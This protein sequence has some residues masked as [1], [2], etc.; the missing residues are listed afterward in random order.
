MPESR[1]N[2][3]YEAGQSKFNLGTFSEFSQ[4]IV[5]DDKRITFF[6]EMSKSYNLGDYQTFT[7]D[8]LKESIMI[9]E[10]LAE[11]ESIGAFTNFSRSVYKG[12]VAQPAAS[13][14]EL[15]GDHK[16]ALKILAESAVESPTRPG[17]SR[18][19]GSVVGGIA[20][21]FAAMIPGPQQTVTVPTVLAHYGLM[22]AGEG[23]GAVKS[24]EEETGKDLSGAHEAIIA[25]GYGATV[26]AAERLGFGALNSTFR[27]IGTKAMKDMGIAYA[28][29][30]PGKVAKI[31]VTELGKLTN[32]S[33]MIEGGEE[34]LEQ[35]MTNAIDATYDPNARTVRQMLHGV[36]ES[37]LGGYVG[38]LVLAGSM[39]SVKA[40]DFKNVKKDFM[41]MA[42]E[43][44]TSFIIESDEFQNKMGEV[45]K[46]DEKY[47]N[48]L[49]DM[50]VT[51]R[52][53]KNSKSKEDG[54]YRKKLESKERKAK[55]E[56]FSYLQEV[57][58]GVLKSQKKI[59]DPE[60]S[61]TDP[62]GKQ[63]RLGN[64]AKFSM[65]MLQG[66][67]DNVDL[68][69]RFN[70]INA[71]RTGEN[72]KIMPSIQAHHEEYSLR[73]IRDIYK[74]FRKEGMS[75]KEANKAMNQLIFLYESKSKW[76]FFP[77]ESK[78]RY[79]KAYDILHNYLESSLQEYK[80]LEGLTYGFVERMKIETLENIEKIR[81]RKTKKD[82][83]L[84]DLKDLE[85]ILSR[86]DYIRYM[87][88]PSAIWFANI[89]KNKPKMAKKVLSLVGVK[90]RKTITIA[91][92]IADPENDIEL[93][94][95]KLGDILASYGRNK[96]RDFAVLE[97][98]RAAEED[99]LAF[100]KGEGVSKRKKII[101]KKGF[102]TKKF[103]HAPK[104]AM[105]MKNYK[106]HPIL[107]ESIEDILTRT[108][109]IGIISKGMNVAKMMAFWNPLFLP[110][111]DT[112]Q[113]FMI[114][115]WTTYKL[116]LYMIQA[117]K[118]YW[119]KSDM[120][121]R[122]KENGIASTPFNNPLQQ[123]IGVAQAMSKA[124]GAWTH[125]L[126]NL[127]VLDKG[128]AL[129]T[130]MT[131]LMSPINIMKTI[132][133]LSWKTARILDGTVRQISFRYLKDKGYTD[134][135]AAQTAALYHGDYAGVPVATRQK[136]NRIFFTPT[137]KIAMGK[138][139]I[140]MIK[141]FGQTI[142]PTI[143]TPKQTRHHMLAF[144]RMFGILIGW[145][146][147]M[148]ALG[149][150]RDE[151]GRRYAK[152]VQTSEG[153]REA[154]LV[155]SGPHNMF[156]KYYSRWKAAFGPEV[157]N[158][159]KHLLKSNSWEIHPVYRVASEIY[160]N[161]DASGK[162]IVPILYPSLK[163]G[164]IPKKELKIAEYILNNI[165][166]IT[167][168][169]KDDIEDPEAREL[170]NKELGQLFNMVIKPFSF[171][172]TRLPKELK[173]LY[174]NHGLKRFFTTDL[175]T[176]KDDAVE[177]GEFNEKALEDITNTLLLRIQEF[178]KMY[179]EQIFPTDNDE[180]PIY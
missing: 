108:R 36:P 151:F 155:W 123:T 87:P 141:S 169:M 176:L 39:G 72:F 137:F 146:L 64:L 25:T 76:Q 154:V 49:E 167:K 127:L 30:Q 136:L 177:T 95:I 2:R 105:F 172:Y 111:Y 55:K 134:R 109:N 122:A 157:D 45:T 142:N 180:E 160:N 83:D 67:V 8:V 110:M 7:K 152:K 97:L 119:T 129:G 46:G 3:L 77:K 147:L 69:S 156:L 71:Q 12:A 162:H 133:N 98:L 171:A 1:L 144:M 60:T 18:F 35:L 56:F 84:K 17:V 131:V 32:L 101:H 40:I 102:N 34:G 138:M 6:D 99:G 58:A 120:Y 92:I 118:D 80:G 135:E 9:Q 61:L 173:Q 27:K 26:F 38:G 23:R 78:V 4:N 113:G 96:G 33:G 15:F 41:E 148:L 150:D 85:S 21:T 51:A 29:R 161:K 114:G 52:K 104:G 100:Q 168:A 117:I 126:R 159:L 116:P 140:G 106:L 57:Q 130:G 63:T 121:W 149:F 143:K 88:I 59:K 44:E 24:F 66:F 62:E 20:P 93:G 165:I 125:I 175:Q 10:Q 37:F 107:A 31:A 54:H 74:A 158:S 19:L 139:Y 86:L 174:G 145:D 28:K 132:Y 73:T 164:G 48:L 153:E 43:A 166:S 91:D 22:A 13:Y 14:Q 75:S 128:I 163:Y 124:G 179:D 47:Q 5:Q 42:G 65:N 79:Q 11:E 112:I 115:A 103:V 89:L 68:Q 170:L 94:D 81:D 70:R 82:T 90:R 178:N 50:E 16:D 53:L